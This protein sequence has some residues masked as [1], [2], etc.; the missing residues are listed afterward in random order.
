MDLFQKFSNTKQHLQIKIF[1]TTTRELKVKLTIVLKFSS[2]ILFNDE[3]VFP[4]SF[5]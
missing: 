5:Y 1:K 2:V 4:L 3:I